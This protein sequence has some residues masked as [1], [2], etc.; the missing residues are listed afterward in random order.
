M[1]GHVCQ[2]HHVQAGG[3]GE[4]AQDGGRRVV[5]RRVEGVEEVGGIAGK[6][7]KEGAM[8]ELRLQGQLRRLARARASGGRGGGSTAHHA[9]RGVPSGG[10]RVKGR[11]ETRRLGE[12]GTERGEGGH[13]EK[14]TGRGRMYTRAADELAVG[15]Q[16]HVTSKRTQ[17]NKK[18]CDK[19]ALCVEDATWSL[20]CCHVETDI[21]HTFMNFVPGDEF[22]REESY[23]HK[24][25]RLFSHLDLQKECLALA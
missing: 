21:L 3:G 12:R 14:R 4:G 8:K 25:H 7:A 16:S 1:D 17:T 19:R 6:V 24:L 18:R 13:K 22:T 2:A 10:R 9:M 23:L 15:T 5:T 20:T 11:G